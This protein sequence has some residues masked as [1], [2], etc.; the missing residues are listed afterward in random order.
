MTAL[1]SCGNGC[2]IA[3][4]SGGM[5]T[6]GGC[7]C[8]E[9]LSA[10]DRLN[11]MRALA[12]YREAYEALR[13]WGEARKVVGTRQHSSH[14]GK[15]CPECDAVFR[16]DD[17]REACAALADRIAAGNDSES[18]KGSSL[19]PGV[20]DFGCLTCGAV[21]ATFDALNEHLGREH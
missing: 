12:T 11:A 20:E 5:A 13:A 16:A 10:S 8:L 9:G 3:K 2:V 14:K 1:V 18:P 15:P 19:A 6:N 7:H 17:K 21:F 4:S